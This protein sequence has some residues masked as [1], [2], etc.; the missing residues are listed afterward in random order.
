MGDIAS[1]VIVY[2]TCDV[3]GLGGRGVIKTWT[4]VPARVCLYMLMSDLTSLVRLQFSHWLKVR[5]VGTAHFLLR[6]DRFLYLNVLINGLTLV[7]API[8]EIFSKC[9]QY[10]CIRREFCQLL[11]QETLRSQLLI[12]LP[13]ICARMETSVWVCSL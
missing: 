10:S 3:I 4:K 5:K 6:P 8:P 13:S 9:Y 2:L 12:S 7:K 11:V 1:D